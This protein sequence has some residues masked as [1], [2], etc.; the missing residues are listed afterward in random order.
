MNE[1]YMSE[2]PA[3]ADDTDQIGIVGAVES[4]TGSKNT[5]FKGF[6]RN[7]SVATYQWLIVAGAVL[8]LWGLG[9]GLR[10]DIKIG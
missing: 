2:G 4:T 5:I 7:V 1:Y 6:G 8:A 10:S 9:Y 3:Y